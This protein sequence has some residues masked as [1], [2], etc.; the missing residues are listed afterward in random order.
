MRLFQLVLQDCNCHVIVSSFTTW[1]FPL[2]LCNCVFLYCI[3]R[4]LSLVLWDRFSLYCKTGSP[5]MVRFLTLVLW[6]CFPLSCEMALPCT[7]RMLPL[8]LW[9][10]SPLHCEIAYPC[11]VNCFSLYYEIASRC[12]LLWNYSLFARTLV[13]TNIIMHRQPKYS[14]RTNCL[15]T[16]FI[17]PFLSLQHGV[18]TLD[19][20]CFLQAQAHLYEWSTSL[21]SL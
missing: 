12:S 19:M 15:H 4:L 11:N 16:Q 6:E 3:I 21:H 9:D 2:V 14:R 10:G 5:C 7:V 20:G 1:L 18:S 13:T 8:E 17:S